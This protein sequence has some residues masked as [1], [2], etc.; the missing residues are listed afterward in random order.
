MTY[1]ELMEQLTLVDL[2][3]D[4]I[5]EIE[6]EMFPVDRLGKQYDQTVDADLIVLRSFE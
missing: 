1:R 6:G 4:V 5:V 3:A 2:D